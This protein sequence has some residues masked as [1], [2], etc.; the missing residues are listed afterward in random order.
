MTLIYLTFT[1]SSYSYIVR[2]GHNISTNTADDT[3]EKEKKLRPFILLQSVRILR[4]ILHFIYIYM[5]QIDCTKT[6]Q[7]HA[8]RTVKNGTIIKKKTTQKHILY[9]VV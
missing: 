9:N 8:I 4:I 1:F 2:S 5:R 3:E 7:S 6:F